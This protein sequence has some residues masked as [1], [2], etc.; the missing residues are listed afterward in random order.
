MRGFPNLPL[1]LVTGIIQSAE[2]A[3]DLRAWCTVSKIISAIARPLLYHEIDLEDCDNVEGALSLFL[4][5]R[6]ITNSSQI[7][8]W[9]QSLRIDAVTTC[10]NDNDFLESYGQLPR[11]NVEGEYSPHADEVENFSIAVNRLEGVYDVSEFLTASKSIPNFLAALLISCTTNLKNLAIHVD[12]NSLTLL[13]ALAQQPLTGYSCLSKIESLCLTS[14]APPKHE[15]DFDSV[16]A[17]LLLL[18]K[19]K[20]IWITGCLGARKNKFNVIRSNRPRQILLPQTLSITHLSFAK[21][22]L[23]ASNIQVLIAACKDLKVF[24]F[25][26]RR[27][28][29]PQDRQF[30]PV[31]LY[32]ALDCQKSKLQDLRVSL[33]TDSIYQAFDW[34]GSTYGS[35]KEYTCMKF[36]QL[37]ERFLGLPPAGFPDSLEYLIV[38]N[39]QSSILGLLSYLSALVLTG[40]ELTALRT[41]SV[42]A[43]ILYPGGMLGLPLK[44]ATELMFNK[45]QQDLVALFLGTDVTL[46][47]ENGLLEKT[48]LGYEVASEDGYSSDYGP[49][50]YTE[51]PMTVPEIVWR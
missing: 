6:T 11:W 1:E 8:G 45:A 33:E 41:I 31:E 12:R 21:S 17:L 50:V 51:K 42:Y 37:D 27:E 29:H 40:T 15:M 46:R 43:H 20:I 38:Q 4:L 30:S 47:F 39:C 25:T 3:T 16:T 28:P 2:D 22:C 48:S 24:S 13:S 36:L 5:T 14:S 26:N 23:T 9:I 35:F 18:P 10:E 19:L 7:A 32:S 34:D 44:G 49:F